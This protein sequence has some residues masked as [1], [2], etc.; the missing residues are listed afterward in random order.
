MAENAKPEFRILVENL[1]L[2]HAVVKVRADEILVLQHVLDERAHLVA[3][4]RAG[5]RRKDT[6]TLTGKPFECI[7]HQTTSSVCCDSDS[8][9]H[10]RI[11][12][13]RHS[14]ESRNQIRSGREN[15]LST[16]PLNGGEGRQGQLN[17]GHE[18]TGA[19]D[20][21]IPVVDL[22]ID[23]RHHDVLDP[24][25]LI[26]GDPRAQFPLVLAVPVRPHRDREFR[27]RP[28]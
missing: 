15:S 10:V 19:F 25:R 21:L 26:S 8:T 20:Y 18:P 23:R 22:A 12:S 17:A 16:A 13:I 3:A 1:P 9:Y 5:I 6:M 28:L 2:R 4:L 7:P 27:L 24:D 11:T 14:R